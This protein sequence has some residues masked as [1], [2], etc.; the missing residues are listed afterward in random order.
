M[1]MI[2]FNNSFCISIEIMCR[3]VILIPHTQTPYELSPVTVNMTNQI[4][5]FKSAVQTVTTFYLQN[6]F[7]VIIL[8]IT[9]ILNFLAVFLTPYRYKFFFSSKIY[10]FPCPMFL[11]PTCAQIRLKSAKCRWHKNKLYLQILIKIV[12]HSSAKTR[13]KKKKDLA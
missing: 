2:E 10:A 8:I 7:S 3:T 5:S 1:T 12:L 6:M 13:T 4:I 11:M 9:E